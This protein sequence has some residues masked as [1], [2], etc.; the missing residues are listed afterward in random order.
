MEQLRPVHITYCLGKFP[1]TTLRHHRVIPSIYL[2][3]LPQ[4]GVCNGGSSHGKVTRQRDGVV[5][6]KS[7][8]LSSLILQV[9]YKLGVFSILPSEDIF[10][11]ENGGIE[12]TSTIE[13]ENV[14]D[15]LFYMFATKHFGRAIVSRPLADSHVPFNSRGSDS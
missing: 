2:S 7:E 9:E 3:N 10:S 14:L 13:V 4:L 8:L 11:F 12:A 6:P 1:H 15:R 5:V